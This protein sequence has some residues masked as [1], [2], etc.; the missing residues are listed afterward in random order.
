MSNVV[1][2]SA[3]SVF[4]LLKAHRV[5]RV[6]LRPFDALP[7]SHFGFKIKF[8]M[9]WGESSHLHARSE[10]ATKTTFALPIADSVGGSSEY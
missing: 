7:V 6:C 1:A 2:P 3:S 10:A 8:S 4:V 9:G 5:P